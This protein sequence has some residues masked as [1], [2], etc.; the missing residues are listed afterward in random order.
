MILGK[1]GACNVQMTS[2]AHDASAPP[3]PPPP[4]SHQNIYEKEFQMTLVQDKTYFTSVEQDEEYFT[5]MYRKV[6]DI[7][8]NTD[9]DVYLS[10]MNT[11]KG[12]AKHGDRA[13]QAVL[14]ELAQLNGNK[15]VKSL[16]PV[17]L[18]L[19][20][21]N[22]DYRAIAFIKE[23]RCGELKGRTCADRE[24][25]THIFRRRVLPFPRSQSRP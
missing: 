13:I 14:S 24:G 25:N 21:T 2:D 12:I 8:M 15:V 17:T 22:K 7:F 3:P 18:P 23:K 20:T 11:K 19:K 6:N 1:K 9:L 4:N 10:Q 5:N 16:N